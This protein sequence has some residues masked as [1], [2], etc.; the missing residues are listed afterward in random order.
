MNAVESTVAGWQRT[1]KGLATVGH[2]S[3]TFGKWVGS[4][5]LVA[6]MV[7]VIY[8]IVARWTG[9]DEGWTFEIEKFGSAWV[10]MV[11]AAYTASRGGHVTAGIALERYV[12]GRAKLVLQTARQLVVVLYL[13]VLFWISGQQ[14]LSSFQL[15]QT[16]ID[17]LHW[18]IWLGQVAIPL[19]AL[20]WLLA[21]LTPAAGKGSDT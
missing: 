1:R 3:G 7:A 21:L 15:N 12:G 16:T 2:C 11:G 8:A 9:A 18:P 5:C 19:G 6:L 20:A 10:A 13:V 4:L 17:S 14:A